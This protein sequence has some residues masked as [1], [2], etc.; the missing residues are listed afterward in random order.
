[1]NRSQLLKQI[2]RIRIG[3]KWCIKNKK[4]SCDYV[5]IGQIMLSPHD[6]VNVDLIAMTDSNLQITVSHRSGYIATFSIDRFNTLFEEIVYADAVLKPYVDYTELFRFIKKEFNI[7]LHDYYKQSTR[8]ILINDTTFDIVINY[9]EKRELVERIVSKQ[10]SHY[11]K[12][13]KSKED[14]KYGVIAKESPRWITEKQ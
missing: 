14:R 4:D 10:K 6:H 7:N 12:N 8:T 9:M 13:E 2:N 3:S 5:N 1:M 11:T